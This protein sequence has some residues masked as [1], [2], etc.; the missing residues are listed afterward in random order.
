MGLIDRLSRA[1]GP[2]TKHA[3]CGSAEGVMD[4]V[5]MLPREVRNGSVAF[6]C[7]A[8]AGLTGPS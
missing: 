5:D 1:I 3:S 4:T 2:D 7:H 6:L 8:L